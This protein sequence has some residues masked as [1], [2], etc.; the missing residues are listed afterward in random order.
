MSQLPRAALA[1]L[2]LAAV[3]AVTG[4]SAAATTAKRAPAA[5]PSTAPL[6]A[7]Q[8]EQRYG[9]RDASGCGSDA[10]L[11][12]TACAT[13]DDP[14]L[15][16][17]DGISAVGVKVLVFADQASRDVW[18]ADWTDMGQAA[19]AKGAWWLILRESP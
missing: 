16:Q 19:I 2:I 9:L 12:I 8:V 14:A 13:A 10:S 17:A 6:S 7:A 1:A 18:L 3:L 11:G 5:K 15:T 4:C